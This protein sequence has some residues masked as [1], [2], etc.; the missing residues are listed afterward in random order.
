V[1]RDNAPTHRLEV[2]G[3]H[4]SCIVNSNGSIGRP[5]HRFKNDIDTGISRLAADE[6]SFI[7]GGYEALLI[8]EPTVGVTKVIVNQT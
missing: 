8:D 2:E 6:L 4:G 7:V 3:R 1:C 5:S